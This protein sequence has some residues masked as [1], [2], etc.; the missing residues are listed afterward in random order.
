V[1]YSV[2]VRPEDEPES[3]A[4]TFVVRLWLE[5]GDKGPRVLRGHITHVMSGERRYVQ[6]L[7]AIEAFIGPF[8][9]RLDVE[10]GG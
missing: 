6:S 10:S 8:M 9:R 3:N 4:E 2:Q 5:G 1:R 7:A